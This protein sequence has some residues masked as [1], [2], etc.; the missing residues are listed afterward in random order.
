M[1]QKRVQEVKNLERRY[2]GE[3]GLAL[4]MKLRIIEIRY[5]N[6]SDLPQRS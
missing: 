6:G 2:P 1:V 3:I 4:Y 5:L